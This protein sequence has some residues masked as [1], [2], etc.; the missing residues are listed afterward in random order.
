MI[1]LEIL[2]EKDPR[3]RFQN[4]A[5]LLQAL[6]TVVGAIDAQRTVT[7]CR[8]QKVPPA[9]SSGITRKPAVRRGPQKVSI[10]RLPVTGS[11]FFGREEDLTFL[12]AAWADPQV[13]VVTIVAWAGVGKSTLINQWLRRLATERYRSAE[14][15]FGWSFYR[16]GTSEGSSSADEFIEAAL[17]WFG[18][19]DPRIGTAW[20]RGERLAKLVA[21]RQTLLVLDGMEPLQNPPGPQE[22]RVRAPSLQ[23]LLRELAAFNAGL[24]V[25]T[26]R[27]PV[28][29]LA[30][31]EGTSALRRDLERLSSEAG[32]KLLRALCVK[33]NDAELRSA[34][35]EFN[36]H[37]L[38]LTLLG[39]YLT[40]AH[41]GDIRC[42]EEVSRR[43]TH[44]LRRGASARKVMESYQTWFGEGP[45]LSMLRVL[46]L[47]DRPAD[48]RVLGMLMKSP[49]IRGLSESLTD[50]SPTE[51]QTI[52]SKLRR[53]RLIAGEDPHNPGYLD[54]HPLV[55][56][57]FGE[58]L[59]D[60]RPDAWRECNR[61]LY[62]YYRTLASE[63]PETFREMEPLF[64]AVICGCHAGLL[65]GALR[66]VYIPRIQRGNDCFAA[67][68]LGARGALLSVLV[69]FFEDGRWG[70]PVENGVEGQSLSAEDQLYILLEAAQHLFVTRGMSAPEAR[71]CYDRAEPLCQSLDRPL[72]LYATLIGQWRYSFMTDR[73]SAT[74]QIAKRLH[75]LTQERNDAVLMIGA[76][77]ALAQTFYFLGDFESARQYAISGLQIWRS[78]SVPLGIEIILCLCCKAQ[79]EWH[80]GE[81]TCQADI[82]EAISLAE[83]LNDRYPLALA[84]WHAGVLAHYERKL[85]ELD[86]LASDLIKLSTRQ[87]FAQWVIGGLEVYF[88]DLSNGSYFS[89]RLIGVGG[90]YSD[91]G[92]IQ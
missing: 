18:D 45:E 65:S 86:H 36:G 71:I 20:E 81:R 6:P 87:N 8:L 16:Q 61:R 72:L 70:S 10:A 43:L 19:S 37:S 30:E 77:R 49:I 78:S 50:L 84:L 3:R 4:P 82:T 55:R 54:T 80:L 35:D 92:T 79:S 64:L 23:T 91:F 28:T 89:V 31:H 1:L 13:K 26:T 39:S 62:H 7:R 46:G 14:L 25:I 59:R 32:A 57:Y 56:E 67:N 52:L 2:L 38:A 83:Q 44:D 47:F 74:L 51:W 48:E 63:F 41:N 85:A 88:F 29:D 42:R 17:A 21:H 73:L 68:V 24:C 12:D 60:Q 9:N 11:D 27:I 75:A 5:Q 90:R 76:D 34:S 58:Q 40:D 33:G 66:E 22:G 69:H 53:A 15:V